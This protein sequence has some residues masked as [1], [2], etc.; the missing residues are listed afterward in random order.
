MSKK[1]VVGILGRAGAGK[2]T[3]TQFA[4]NALLLHGTDS[5][6]IAFADPLYAGVDAMFP[7]HTFA[8][9]GIR[10]DTWSDLG[11]HD[12]ESYVLPVVGK[13]L[14]QILQTLGTEWGRDVISPNL[15]VDLAHKR[16]AD[17]NTKVV[18]L[19]DV[20]FVTELDSIT[21]LNGQTINGVEYT[22]LTVR[23]TRDT[24]DVTPHSGHRSEAPVFDGFEP[25]LSIANNG[26]IEELQKQAN[27]LCKVI[28]NPLTKLNRINSHAGQ[29]HE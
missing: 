12:K 10:I 11:R 19:T 16:I 2:D 3:L 1:V 9:P 15:W 25:T 26:T 13:T 27:H 23:I 18:F 24:G 6:A 29:F 28:L 7:P 22:A 8:P 17:A 4:R 21:S 14:R 5:S 20:R